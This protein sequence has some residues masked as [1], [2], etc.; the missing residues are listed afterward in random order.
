MGRIP[1][2]NQN[3]RTFNDDDPIV[4]YYFYNLNLKDV[5]N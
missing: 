4:F 2:V 1:V 3:P 5:P